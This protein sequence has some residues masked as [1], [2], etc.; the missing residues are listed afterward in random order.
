MIQKLLSII[1]LCLIS[2][3]SY[4][5]VVNNVSQL[6]NAINSASSG[7]TIILADGTRDWSASN[8]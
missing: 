8:Q 4:A 5:Q 1:T 2:V 6:N 3:L 7:T